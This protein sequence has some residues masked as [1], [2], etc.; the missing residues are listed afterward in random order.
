L[1]DFGASPE[2]NGSHSAQDIAGIITQALAKIA[3][4]KYTL[5]GTSFGVNVAL[6]QTLQAP[7][8]VEALILIS[9]TCLMPTGGMI[10]ATPADMAERLFAHPEDAT[11]LPTYDADMAAKELSLAQRLGSEN[12]DI[13]MEQRLIEIQCATLVAVAS[14]DKLVL[15]EAA[16]IYRAKISNSDVSIVTTLDMLYWPSGLKL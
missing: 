1:P 4:E 3:P 14:Q 6:W 16:S 15:S 13:E 5:I 2:N 11:S 8:S 10:Y 7:N 12:H 9:L